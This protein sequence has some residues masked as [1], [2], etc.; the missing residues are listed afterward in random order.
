MVMSSP[1]PAA[2]VLSTFPLPKEGAAAPSETDAKAAQHC[3]VAVATL[4]ARPP[5][6]S[7]RRAATPGKSGSGSGAEE[8]DAAATLT[9]LTLRALVRLSATAL[10]PSAA[11]LE[12]PMALPALVEAL[13]G[14]GGGGGQRSAQRSAAPPFPAEVRTAMLQLLADALVASAGEGS[15]GS[16]GDVHHWDVVRMLLVNKQLLPTLVVG[17]CVPVDRLAV[18]RCFSGEC[19]RL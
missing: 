5:A 14:G 8:E 13:T 4:L 6:L 1:L 10:D 18:L 11:L 16:F 7:P 19:L 3:V 17:V 15:G 2:S 12:E 9:R